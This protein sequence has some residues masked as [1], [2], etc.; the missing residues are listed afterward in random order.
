LALAWWMQGP[1]FSRCNV[2]KKHT[3]RANSIS[4]PLSIGVDLLGVKLLTNL[5]SSLQADPTVRTPQKILSRITELTHPHK[6][7]LNFGP[8][9]FLQEYIGYWSYNFEVRSSGRAHD[10]PLYRSAKPE[11]RIR[12]RH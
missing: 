5:K 4:L 1:L 12:I 2:E 9:Y 6:A 7:L 11:L 8:M 3:D 10:A